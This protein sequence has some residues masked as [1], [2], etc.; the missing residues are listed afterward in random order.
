M[1]APAISVE[2]IP[3]GPTL[4]TSG[5]EISGA[6]PEAFNVIADARGALRKRPGIAAYSVAPATAVD[7][8]GVLGLY[9][10]E[11]RVAHTS[12]TAIVSGEHPGVLYAVGATVNAAGGGHNAGRNVY[13]IA[14]GTAT[15]VGTGT[16]NEDRLA[17]PAALATTRS[18]RPVFAE[19][20]A[21]LVI[22]GAAEIGKIDIRPELFSAPNFSTNPDYHEMSFLGGCPPLASHVFTNSSRICANDTQLDQTKVR[23]S[24]ISQGI[25][26]FS[27]HEDWAPSPGG[28]GFFTAE[29]RSDSLVACAENTN[30]I[31]LF[32]T[33]SLQLFTP[34]SAI[35]FAPAITKEAGCLAPYSPVKL[36]D[37]YMWLDHQTRVVMS[38]GRQWSDIGKQIQRTLDE[39]TA[40][41]ECY[42]YRFAESF[43][44]CAVLRFNTDQQ[45]L[46]FQPGIGWGKWAQHD[47]ATDTFT[48]FPVLSHHRRSDGGLNVV[49]LEDGTIRTLSL[50]HD[51]DLGAAIVAYVST[52]F[53]DRDSDNRKLSVG[54]TLTFKRTSALSDGVSCYIEYR[55]E[56]SDEWTSIEIDLGVEDGNMT[57]SIELRSLGIYRRRQWRFRF[58]D[59]AGLYLVRA[60]E[61]FIA[62]DS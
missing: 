34:D 53:L 51:T 62:L 50:D 31:F 33:T 5:E 24:G 22:A 57:P 11:R 61:K 3:F 58:A 60:T 37:Q 4:D 1:P 25:V 20:E 30:D 2:V 8:A 39:L 19:T 35:T 54:V 9:L 15:L 45:T 7:A 36:D 16:A 49:G 43:A 21:L 32:G 52:G 38:D 6:S 10:T 13:R 27:A 48:M 59:E 41:R 47:A 12:G 14:G 44:D 42:A 26:D 18:P 40:P 28:P 23:F 17:T 46:V 55:D 29:A 56:L